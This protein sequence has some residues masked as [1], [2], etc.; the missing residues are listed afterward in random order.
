MATMVGTDQ[1]LVKIFKDN[2][3]GKSDW[4]SICEWHDVYVIQNET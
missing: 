4:N 1:H 3:N 2:N